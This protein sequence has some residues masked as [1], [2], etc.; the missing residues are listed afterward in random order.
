MQDVFHAL[1]DHVSSSLQG[2]ER[3][4]LS[5]QN[6]DTDFVRFNGGRVRQAGS[7][8]QRS[9]TLRLIAGSR[10]ASAD[11]GLTGDL[12]IDRASIDDNLRYLRECLPYLPEDPHLNLSEEVRSTTQQDENHLPDTAEVVE[13]IVTA[14]HGDDLVGILASGG[15]ERGFA[16]SYGQRN[17]FSVHNFN[18]VNLGAS[19][20][21]R[22]LIISDV[23]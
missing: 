2:D 12:G 4:T 23:F 16:N 15:I 19:D 13:Q 22:R 20:D 8:A 14:A 21:A 18:V 17:W 1:T 11:M 9:L 5:F 3:F 10:Q 7:V 6:E